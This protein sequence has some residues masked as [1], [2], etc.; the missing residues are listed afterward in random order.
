MYNIFC[1]LKII[2]DFEFVVAIFVCVNYL[3]YFT[4]F[5]L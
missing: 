2:L 3:K 4:S 5:K 1:L